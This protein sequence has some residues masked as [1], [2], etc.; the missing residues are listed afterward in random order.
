MFYIYTLTASWRHM[1]WVMLF[2]IGPG[3]DLPPISNKSLKYP[4]LFFFFFF[5]FFW[6]GGVLIDQIHKSHNAPVPYPTMPHSEQKCAHSCSEC[7]TVGYGTGESWCTF[8]FWMVHYEIW[9][10]CIV[11]L[12]G[13]SFGRITVFHGCQFLIYVHTQWVGGQ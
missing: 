9:D 7:C 4:I 2:S 10:R 5:F 12:W 13:W 6:G 8:L 11:D 3:N 1:A